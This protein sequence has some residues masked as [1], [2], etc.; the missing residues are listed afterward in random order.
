MKNDAAYYESAYN[1]RL[2][3]PQYADHFERWRKKSATARAAL[4]GYLDVPYGSHP[5]EKLDIF[6]AKGQSRALLVFIHG[7]Y[8]RGAGQERSLVYRRA[9]RRARRDRG[10]AQLRARAV[11]ACPGH[12]AAGAA[13]VRVAVSQ[14]R[15]LRRAGGQVV[16]GRPLRRWASDRHDLGGAVA[17]VF[18]GPAEKSSASRSV[19][20]RRVRRC[21]DHAHAFDQCGRP[22]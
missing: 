5:M 7:G 21:A 16:R 17:Q 3:V 1:P 22:V 10:A 18:S 19:H 14:R 12:R 15:Q 6:R 9:V 11:R 20:Q 2:V 13:G 4:S 8:W